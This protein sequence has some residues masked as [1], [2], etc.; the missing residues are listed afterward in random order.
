MSKVVDGELNEISLFVDDEISIDDCAEWFPLVKLLK[1]LHKS[2]EEDIQIAQDGLCMTAVK[3]SVHNYT[4]SGENKWNLQPQ[5]NAFLQSVL[6]LTT[7]IKDKKRILFIT[8]F[9]SNSAPPGADQVEA[10]YECYKFANKYEQELSDDSKAVDTIKKIRRKYPIY[11]TQH[12]LHMHGLNDEKLMQLV[13]NPKELIISMYFHGSLIESDNKVNINHVAEEIANLHKIDCYSLQAN[14][15]RK[16]LSFSTEETVDDCDQTYI[17]EL[18]TTMLG[19][20]TSSV[21]EESVAR[22]YYILRS[23]TTLQS[24]NFLISHVS[25]MED[26]DNTSSARQLQAMECLIRLVDEATDDIFIDMVSTPQYIALK[27]VHNLKPFGF[28]FTIEK[29]QSYD[30]LKILKQLWAAHSN[31]AKALE[32]ISYICIGYNIYEPIIWDNLLKQMANLHMVK[33][34]KAIMEMVTM[35]H[36]LIHLP[37]LLAAWE[38]IIRCPLKNIRRER[39]LEQDEALCQILFTLQSCPIKSKMNLLDFAETC[40]RFQQVHVAAIFVAFAKGEQRQNILDLIKNHQ[41][42]GLRK[43]I[44][45]LEEFGIYPIITKLVLHELGL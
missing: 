27:C 11:R 1:S 2:T 39:S 17:D 43:N 12:L 13:E 5:K 7:F 20:D 35:K 21:C 34:L 28:K 42:E 33:E 45:D 44:L 16:W 19:T 23:W 15:L 41:T 18:N 10:A 25:N 26:S 6:N 9:L 24:T 30:K 36:A 8:Y 37:G 38:Y 29:F 22:A 40:V 4:I 31:V 32:V 3:S 14:L